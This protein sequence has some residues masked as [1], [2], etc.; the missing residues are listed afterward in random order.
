MLIIIWLYGKEQGNASC[1]VCVDSKNTTRH[2]PYEVLL[3]V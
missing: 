1:V 3:L 2:N